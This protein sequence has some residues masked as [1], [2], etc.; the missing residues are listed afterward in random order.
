MLNSN[1]NIQRR[2]DFGGMQRVADTT[3]VDAQGRYIISGAAPITPN[4]S[5]VR[6][7]DT[8]EFVNTTGSVWQIK[9]GISYDF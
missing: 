5:G 4:A 7:F 1:W 3:G 9:M 6:T 8:D 2:R